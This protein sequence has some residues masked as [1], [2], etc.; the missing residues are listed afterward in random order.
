M[1][2]MLMA[3]LS[4]SLCSTLLLA[5]E[6]AEDTKKVTKL[7]EFALKE[8]D[9][10]HDALHPLV[11]EALPNNDYTTIRAGL[12]DLLTKAKAIE[13]ARLPRKFASRRKEFQKQS[14][15]LVSQ[16]ADMNEVKNKIDGDTL[17]KKF[18]DMHETFETLVELVR[19]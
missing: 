6:K 18:N 16:L 10:F 8:L 7:H 9:I 19:E 4:V 3:F 14:K 17:G 5:Q 11:H 12:Q 2:T 1:K 13:K 15:L